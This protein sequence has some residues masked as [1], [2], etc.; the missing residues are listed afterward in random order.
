[1]RSACADPNFLS[2]KIVTVTFSRTISHG[3]FLQCYALQK[4]LSDLGHEV[5]VLDYVPKSFRRHAYPWR[6]FKRYFGIFHPQNYVYLYKRRAFSLAM[7]KHL[8]M[9]QLYTSLEELRAAPP[10]AD[11]YVC[12]S[13]QIWNPSF[14]RN[15]F[16]PAFFCDF[17]KQETKRI[18]YA[19]SFGRYDLE[20]RYIEQLKQFLP[21]MDSLSTRESSGC[22]IVRDAC[23]L[24]C[25][26][27]MD[28]TFL[29]DDYSELYSSVPRIPQP[30]ILVMPMPGQY[31]L[32]SECLKRI[33]KKTSLPFVFI[34]RDWKYWI[35]PGKTVFC[36]PSNWLNLFA[37]ASGVITNSFHG[38]AF[39][40][41][42]KK[43]FITFGYTDKTRATRNVRMENLLKHLDLSDRYITSN[44]EMDKIDQV[45]EPL[46]WRH[47][48]EL[49][50]ALT[51][52][53]KAYL[54]SALEA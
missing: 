53:S 40:L 41:H 22:N 26:H 54:H 15:E 25:E 20:P 45:L 17:G 5:E 48:D 4:Y 24:D 11:A 51:Q 12:G 8:N 35:Y 27:V 46:D 7:R 47:V 42:L 3:A 43:P 31:D 2:M 49:K 36:S 34:G 33:R 19:A 1:M 9:T 29:I 13:D 50:E 10:Q 52:K 21:K 30:Y 14:F 32:I 37:N 23:G 44:E 6:S 39:C 28:P 38:T 16:D 18:A